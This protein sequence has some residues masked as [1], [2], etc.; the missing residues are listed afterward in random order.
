MASVDIPPFNPGPTNSQRSF[1]KDDMQRQPSIKVPGSSPAPDSQAMQRSQSSHLGRR[2]ESL[3]RRT[4]EMHADGQP[5][6]QHRSSSEARKPVVRIQNYVIYRKTIGQGSMGKVKM[7]ECL[8]DRDQQKYAVKIMPKMDL[9]AAAAST[10]KPKDPKDT[11]KEREQRTIRELAIMHLLRHPNICQLKEWVIEGDYYYMFLEYVD[12]GQ[13]LDYIIQHGKLREKQARKFARQIA[14]ALDYCHRNSIV[15][16]D[17][18]IENIL[19]THD[20]NIKIIDFGLSNIYSPSRLL[21]TFCG[22]LYF[23]APELLKARHY[24]GPEVDVWSFGVVLYVLVCGRVPFDDTSLP[25]LHA[26][27]KSGIVDEYPDHLSKDCVD[28]LSKI[29][30]VDPRKR[31]TLNA[32]ESHPWMKKGYDEPIQSMIPKRDILETID[33]DMVRGMHGFGLGDEQTIKAKLERL[34]HTEE[35]KQAVTKI[36]MNQQMEQRRQH[37]TQ[38]PLWRRSLST[39]RPSTADDDP[40]SLPAMYDPLLSIYYLVK[41]RKEYDTRRQLDMMNKPIYHGTGLSRSTSTVAARPKAVSGATPSSTM[42][43]RRKTDGSKST[44]RVATSSPGSATGQPHPANHIPI[45]NDIKAAAA[46]ITAAAQQ[47]GAASLTPASSSAPQRKASIGSRLYRNSSVRQLTRSVT[48][49]TNSIRERSKSAVKILGSMLPNRPFMFTNKHTS[50]DPVPTAATMTTMVTTTT[51]SSSEEQPAVLGAA[52][53]PPTPLP[54]ALAPSLQRKSSLNAPLP[55]APSSTTTANTTAS[56]SPSQSRSTPHKKTGSPNKFLDPSSGQHY[57]Q[58]RRSWRQLSLVRQPTSGTRMSM[59]ANE[60]PPLPL[61]TSS[62]LPG[63]GRYS[64]SDKDRPGVRESPRSKFHLTR[65]PLFRSDSGQHLLTDLRQLLT[66]LNIAVRGEISTFKLACQCGYGEWSK[67]TKH[68]SS[69]G[70]DDLDQYQ[71]PFL[72]AVSVYQAKWIHGRFGIKVK[73]LMVTKQMAASLVP[74]KYRSGHASRICRAIQHQIE[75]EMEKWLR[76]QKRL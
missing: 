29:L 15:H 1:R 13:L 6:K 73:E 25:A 49:R 4:N 11:P 31:L 34:I 36:N 50:V 75:S 27:I 38:R 23:A 19:L 42:L 56:P 44:P 72:F 8:T 71:Q 12:G 53:A 59:D 66:S 68:H 40:A 22:S 47:A 3:R 52:A 62:S 64:E 28:L 5:P 33:I 74:V 21:S 51:S 54:T 26:K 10:E 57:H 18:K 76:I 70:M 2:S 55:P 32:I 16:R 60:K 46:G 63:V 43:V 39:R 41:E 20:E 65:N 14:S 37:Q 24:T 35:Y 58:S 45:D 48:E 30:V 69:S 61:P 7:A 17:L 67:W 9:K